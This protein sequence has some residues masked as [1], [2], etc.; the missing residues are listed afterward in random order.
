MNYIS[1]DV[2]V[3]DDDS[4]VILQE[5]ESGVTV[6]SEDDIGTIQT[7]D[8]GPPGVRGNSV[9]YGPNDPLP[10]NGVDGD[11]YIN[12]T[13]HFM[14][15]P[16]TI[17]IWFAPGVSLVGPQGPAGPPGVQGPM[18]APGLPGNQM[19]YGAGPPA[20]TLGRPGDSYIDQTNDIL[21]GPKQSD[22]T[23][24]S[25]GASLIGPPGPV[26]P[27]G[28]PP[29]KSPP[30]TWSGSTA[31]TAVAP[32][33]LVQN[34]GSTYVCAVSHTST[35]NFS[36][37]LAAGKWKAIGATGGGGSGSTVYIG[38][39]PPTGIDDNSLWW[40]TSDGCL[41]IYFND[42]NS[43]QWVISSPVADLSQYLALSGGTLTGPLIQAA[44]PVAPL[45][46]ATKQYVDSHGGGG[47]LADAPS[48]GFD[49]GRKNAAWDKVLSLGGGTMTGAIVLAADPAA[50]LQPATKQYTDAHA[51]IPDA[52][53]DGTL[54]GRKNAA[55]V[56]A[57]GASIVISDT[58]P[59]TPSPGQ[60]W[61]RSTDGVMF[62]YYN[63]GDSSQWVNAGQ[64]NTINAVQWDILQALSASQQN[65]A[66]RNIGLAAMLRSHLAG[67]TL[68]N[69][70]T[71]TFN[72]APGVAADS[73]NAD[74]MSL[75]A[76]IAKTTAAWA[77]GSTN[78]A[79]DTGSIASSTWYHIFLIKRPDT[80]VVDVLISLSP[81]A[82]TLPA[83]YTLFRRIGS[84]RTAGT[85]QWVAFIQLGDEFIW[86][87][88]PNDCNALALS[89]ANRTLAVLTVPTGIQVQA[90]IRAQLN[91]SGAL[92]A[93]LTSP[94]ETDQAATSAAGGV[95]IRVTAAGDAS[96]NQ[97]M[98]RTDTSGRI[99]IRAGGSGGTFYCSTYG[100]RD[101]R[102]KDS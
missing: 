65:I 15:G 102:G 92:A 44:D 52:P 29:W 9:L 23:W 48:D 75:T 64:A 33:D 70:A 2:S 43:K 60:L 67:L 31:Y 86:A 45:G 85:G 80:G 66:Q 26:G 50:P 47:G 21:Y 69:G 55:W 38:D 83:S 93:T 1:G 91:S 63:D 96:A 14:W 71:I 32:A 89:S 61:W 40:N 35:S 90:M 101:T 39:N 36:T 51:G 73:T 49:Y 46:T 62:I 57:S 78:G 37:D 94:D 25:S 27:A 95:S 17:G 13:S 3:Q 30:V 68:S 82:P 7:G 59:P 79:L 16:K 34:G 58:A 84:L 81:T 74:M 6:I 41:Y 76:S 54:Y 5:I 11:F 8:Q 97:Q 4:I 87:V 42:G 19:Y 53:S 10:S 99:A 24:P 28:P 56:A 18:G 100:W 98:I 72:V 22:N 88:A 12:T 20:N 77:V